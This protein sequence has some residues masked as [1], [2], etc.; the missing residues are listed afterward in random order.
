MKLSDFASCDL[1][2]LWSG[3]LNY[4]NSMYAPSRLRQV[5]V[6]YTVDE[7][8]SPNRT[9]GRTKGNGRSTCSFGSVGRRITCGK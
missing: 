8:V 7:E 3:I 9:Q 1:V 6:S 4:T 2:A 5:H